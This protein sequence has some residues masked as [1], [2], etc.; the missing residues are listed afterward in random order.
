MPNFQPAVKGGFCTARS[1]LYVGAD[2]ARPNRSCEKAP[3]YEEGGQIAGGDQGGVC[4]SLLPQSRL[5]P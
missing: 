4:K 1:I 3:L 5:T 2:I